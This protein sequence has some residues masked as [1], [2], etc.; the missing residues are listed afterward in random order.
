MISAYEMLLGLG[1][2]FVNWE[3]QIGTDLAFSAQGKY[4]ISI[5][6]SPFAWRGIVRK[7]M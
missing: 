3:E 4:F 6:F 1:F 7:M 2:C 5:Q